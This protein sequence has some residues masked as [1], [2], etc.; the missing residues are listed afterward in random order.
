M[1]LQF[2]EDRSRPRVELHVGLA[3]AAEHLPAG[4]EVLLGG[5]GG[6]IRGG[7][8]LDYLDDPNRKMC[9][10]FL[11]LLDKADVH[12]KSFGDST[13]PLSSL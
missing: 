11:S 4:S 6:K 8:V 2:A 12:L 10:L 13:E 7:R 5:G 9:S 1:L 3:H